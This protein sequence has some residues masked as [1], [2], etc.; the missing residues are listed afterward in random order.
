LLYKNYENLYYYYYYYY[1]LHNKLQKGNTISLEKD[2][3]RE[4]STFSLEKLQEGSTISLDNLQEDNA[5]RLDKVQECS[6]ANLDKNTGRQLMRCTS[7][8]TCRKT[9]KVINEIQHLDKVISTHL[10]ASQLLG[11]TM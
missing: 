10:S 11:D 7:I 5:L 8:W 2:K 6:T 9:D 4:C 1:Y 3:I